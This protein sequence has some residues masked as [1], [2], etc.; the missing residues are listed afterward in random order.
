MEL[1]QRVAWK[2]ARLTSGES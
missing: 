2:L 1:R